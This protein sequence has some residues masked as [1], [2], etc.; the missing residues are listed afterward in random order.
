M[1]NTKVKLE[2][3]MIFELFVYIE[4]QTTLIKKII[5]RKW[6]QTQTTLTSEDYI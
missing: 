3:K 2:L 1:M 6:I 4:P 5:Y